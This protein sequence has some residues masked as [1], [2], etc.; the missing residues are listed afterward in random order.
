MMNRAASAS[1]TEHGFPQHQQQQQTAAAAAFGLMGWDNANE[2]GPATQLTPPAVSTAAA[3]PSPSNTGTKNASDPSRQY[4]PE[5]GVMRDQDFHPLT[6][7]HQRDLE[8]LYQTGSC[9]ADFYFWQA[10]LGG[11]CM[12]DM[13][14]SKYKVT[15]SFFFFRLLLTQLCC[16]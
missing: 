6:L 1:T 7:K 2:G 14:Q 10:N 15:L 8:N 4:H 3:A 5:W 12:A 13:V 16:L 11:Y 9:I